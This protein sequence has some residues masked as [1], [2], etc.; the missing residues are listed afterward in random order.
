MSKKKSFLAVVL[1]IMIIVT[2]SAISRDAEAGLQG[3]YLFEPPPDANSDEDFGLFIMPPEFYNIEDLLA[4]VS[5]AKFAE[6]AFLQHDSHTYG[7]IHINY[8]TYELRQVRSFYIPYLPWPDFDLVFIS[9]WFPRSIGLVFADGDTWISFFNTYVGRGLIPIPDSHLQVVWRQDDRDHRFE[10]HVPVD[11]VEEAVTYAV[12]L[13]AWEIQG[14]AISASIQ[15]ADRVRIFDTVG[16]EISIDYDRTLA[17]LYRQN[18][19]GTTIRVGYRWQI[20]AEAHRYQFVMEPGVYIFRGEGVLGERDIYVR[21]FEDHE[22]V[23]SLSHADLLEQYGAE[24]FVLVV[25]GINRRHILHIGQE[26]S[27]LRLF[28]GWLDVVDL[29]NETRYMMDTAPMFYR[30]RILVDLSFIVEHMGA[31]FTWD[32][33]EQR[34]AITLGSQELSL[35]TG[36]LLP[37]MDVAARI[38]NGRMMLPLRFV[39]EHLGAIVVW[40][41]HLGAVDIIR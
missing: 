19:D 36:E 20:C 13:I 21:Y 18:T 8:F 25:D 2:L 34:I 38:V 35:V 33:N 10:L 28:P 37:G 5:R 30:S 23:A 16:N 27:R 31:E 9:F 22:I 3:V 7:Y 32:E 4:N 40:H 26:L 39:A 41:D 6:N 11:L 14:N 29:E 12:P 1:A 24:Q 17:R 15:G